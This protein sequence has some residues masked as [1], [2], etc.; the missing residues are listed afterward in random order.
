MTIVR[1][2]DIPRTFACSKG[3]RH[4]F[5][6]H[7]LDWSSFLKN[8]VDAECLSHIKDPRLVEIIE[9]ANNR[10]VKENGQ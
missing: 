2:Q 7:S 5:D 10:E 9:R 8:G 3:L 6:H 4:W 1:R